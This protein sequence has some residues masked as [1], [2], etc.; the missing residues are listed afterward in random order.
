MPFTKYKQ[1]ENN[2]EGLSHLQN[3]HNTQYIIKVNLMT[4]GIQFLVRCLD[5]N[6]STCPFLL[7]TLTSLE[8]F[9]KYILTI[10]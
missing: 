9:L 2:N 4:W 6:A 5:L 8:R 3:R 7:L 10:I 1:Q